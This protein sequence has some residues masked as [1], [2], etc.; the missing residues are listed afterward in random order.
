MTNDA[1]L[2]NSDEITGDERITFSLDGCHI[3][4]YSMLKEWL[5][6]AYGSHQW[7]YDHLEKQ[8]GTRRLRGRKP[9][10]AGEAR[11][12]PLLIKEIHHGGLTAK[13]TKDLFI[14]PRRFTDPMK[15]ADFLIKNG[16]YTPP[17]IFAAWRRAGLFVKGESGVYY[18]REG[19]D[20]ADYLFPASGEIPSKW[21]EA[22][23]GIAHLVADLHHLDFLHPDLN[24]MNFLVDSDLRVHVVDLDKSSLPSKP[25]TLLKKERNLNR[26][27]RSIRKIGSGRDGIDTEGYVKLLKKE[28]QEANASD[29]RKKHLPG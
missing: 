25:L 13:I 23:A 11:S 18:H 15:V 6:D 27:V 26:L 4:A 7:A 29:T 2:R 28:Y 1:R 8:E 19:T 24:L 20:A 5:Q 16:I 17:I 14:T 9:V 21:R 12:I 3:T 22:V 10:V